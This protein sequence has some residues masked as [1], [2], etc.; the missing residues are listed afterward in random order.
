MAEG[1]YP[2]AG[3][4]YPRNYDGLVSWFLDDGACLRYLERL[5]WGEG[6]SCRFCGQVGG[7]YW[8]M[9]DGLRRCGPGRARM[10]RIANASGD[11]LSEFVLDNVARGSEVS[12]DA[13]KGYNDIGRY[14]FSPK[15]PL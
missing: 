11:V 8:R 7:E 10:Q 1:A 14:R 5:R 3:V 13:W 2:V 9:G 15:F 4:D 6:F 12:T